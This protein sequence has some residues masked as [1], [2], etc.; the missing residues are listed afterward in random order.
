MIKKF[1][2]ALKTHL[3]TSKLFYLKFHLFQFMRECRIGLMLYHNMKVL[4]LESVDFIQLVGIK[5]TF[6]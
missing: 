1:F 5:K 2:K 6:L 4:I 3:L